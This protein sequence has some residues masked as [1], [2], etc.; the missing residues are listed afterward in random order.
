MMQCII[1]TTIISSS[2][3]SSSFFFFFPFVPIL[4]VPLSLA[5]NEVQVLESPVFH[6]VKKG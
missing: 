4:Y 1:T 3:S 5:C 2:S 6:F